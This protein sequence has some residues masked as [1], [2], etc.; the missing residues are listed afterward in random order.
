MFTNKY[1]K[2][3]S[4]PKQIFSPIFGAENYSIFIKKWSGYWD[5]FYCSISSCDVVLWTE[6]ITKKGF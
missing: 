2:R 5:E 1:Y 6:L 3:E 4:S